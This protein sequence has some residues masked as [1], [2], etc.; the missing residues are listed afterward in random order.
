MS[1]RP[2]VFFDR[3]G[4][5]MEE[6]DYCNNPADVRAIAG[7]AAGL[8]RLREAG[9]MI[10][11]ITNQSGLSSGKIT[12]AQYEAVNAELGRQLDGLIDAVYFC[13]DASA[14]PTHRRKPGTG[15]LDE[16][17]IDHGIDLARSWMIGDK[18]IDILCGKTAGCRTIL[19]ETGYGKKHLSVGANFITPDVSAAMEIVLGHLPE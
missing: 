13:P 16:A 18:D 6:V 14:N 7:A 10:V 4:T 5:L 3:D 9:W 15:M 19:V 1:D 2:A 11:I 8:A 12:Q 17:S